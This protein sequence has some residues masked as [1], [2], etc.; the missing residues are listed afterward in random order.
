MKNALYLVILEIYPVRCFRQ[1]PVNPVQQ[2]G[3]L[4]GLKF[5]LVD[6]YLVDRLPAL[7]INVHRLK[8][9]FIYPAVNFKQ[10]LKQLLPADFIP[11]FIPYRFIHTL[12]G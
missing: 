4:C 7:C 2:P 11:Q 12:A 10:F 9:Q 6:P 3:Q 8:H 1:C 5:S